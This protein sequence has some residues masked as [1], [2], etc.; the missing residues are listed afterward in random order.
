LPP[1]LIFAAIWFA[2]VALYEREL[3]K[4]RF[5]ATGVNESCKPS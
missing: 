5:A 3:R 4:L 1:I 2:T